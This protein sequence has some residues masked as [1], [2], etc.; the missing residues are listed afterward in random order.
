MSAKRL[1][2]PMVERTVWIIDESNVMDVLAPSTPAGQRG[3]KGRIRENTRLWVIGV[4]LL[5]AVLMDR[6][7]QRLRVRSESRAQLAHDHPAP[8]TPE[9][10]VSAPADK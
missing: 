5:G 6:A 4:I 3:R 7:L 10:A 8:L 1:T 9:P 2:R